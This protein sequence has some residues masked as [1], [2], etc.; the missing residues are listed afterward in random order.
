MSNDGKFTGT[1]W[2]RPSLPIPADG[3]PMVI[4]AKG[5]KELFTQ[6]SW[7]ENVEKFQKTEGLMAIVTMRTRRKLKETYIGQ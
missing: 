2:L 5:E 6:R 1:K 7:I 3:E 4:V